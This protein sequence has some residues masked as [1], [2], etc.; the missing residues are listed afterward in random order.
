MLTF[1]MVYRYLPKIFAFLPRGMLLPL[2]NYLTINNL[3][4]SLFSTTHLLFNTIGFIPTFR[5]L[6]SLRGFI[7]GVNNGVIPARFNSITNLLKYYP[8][9][10][11]AGSNIL[12][13]NL[14][15]Y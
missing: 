12:I 6:M 9:L 7:Q 4:L 5:I 15:S 10:N 13:N 3:F 8:N 14:S 1:K 2:K 11:V